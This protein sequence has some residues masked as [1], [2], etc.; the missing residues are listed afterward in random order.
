MLTLEDCIAMS[1]LRPDEI[2]AIAEIQHLPQMIAAELGCYLMQL[3][4]GERRVETLLRQDI[5]EAR[6]LGDFARAAKLRLC[7]QRFVMEHPSG[8]SL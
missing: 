4:D 6:R 1:E 3:P 8:T 2:E 5:A 7:L